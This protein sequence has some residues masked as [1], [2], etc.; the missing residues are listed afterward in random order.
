M[1]IAV[2]GYRGYTDGPFVRATL[3]RWLAWCN[4]S[5]QQAHVRVG[6]AGGADTLVL[7][8]CLDNAVSHHVFYA[9]WGNSGMRAGPERN[10]RMLRGTGDR[11]SG[12][13]ELLMAFPRPGGPPIRIPG[14]GTWGC[15]IEAFG[16]G[17]RVDIPA[18]KKSGD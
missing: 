7:K 12:P 8:W 14:S 10:R 2:T 13:T 17:I 18:Y 4:Q 16:M 11:V 15:C 3:D 5:A 6:D 1:I 9:D